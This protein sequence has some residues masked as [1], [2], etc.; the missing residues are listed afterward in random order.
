MF[1]K[2][3]MGTFTP[4]KKLH[5]ALLYSRDRLKL[6]MGRRYFPLP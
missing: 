1:A 4:L 3:P 5:M 2:N 6:T